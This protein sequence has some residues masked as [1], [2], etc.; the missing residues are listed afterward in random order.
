MALPIPVQFQVQLAKII[1]VLAPQPHAA[2]PRKP[3]AE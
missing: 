1:Q 2:G 3:Q